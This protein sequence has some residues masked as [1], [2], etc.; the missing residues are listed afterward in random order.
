[1]TVTII[2]DD[3]DGR[4]EITLTCSDWRTTSL[5]GSQRVR[6]WTLKSCTSRR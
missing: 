4:P 5:S 6:Q 1:M 3:A 2:S